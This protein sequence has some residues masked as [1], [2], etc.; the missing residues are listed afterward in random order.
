VDLKAENFLLRGDIDV[1]KAKILSLETSDPSVLSEKVI[2]PISQEYFEGNRYLSNVII[3]GVSE[4][5][6][7]ILHVRISYD[8]TA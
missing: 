6:S 7:S 5:T 1:L 2:A 8:K 4:S 3:Y